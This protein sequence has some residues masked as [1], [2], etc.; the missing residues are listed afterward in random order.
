MSHGITHTDNMF[1]VRSMPWHGLGVVLQ[2]QGIG[3][4]TKEG[5]NYIILDPNK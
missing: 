3:T 4:V 2:S 1:S 5:S